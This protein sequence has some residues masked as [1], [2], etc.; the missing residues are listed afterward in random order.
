MCSVAMISRVRRGL[1]ELTKKA[2]IA[3][4][5]VDGNKFCEL[6]A[7]RGDGKEGV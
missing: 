6:W 2:K 1:R 3:K 7:R 5:T 4:I